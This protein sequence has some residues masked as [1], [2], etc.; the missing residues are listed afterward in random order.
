MREGAHTAPPLRPRVPSGWGDRPC[1]LPFPEGQH[2]HSELGTKG[3]SSLQRPGLCGGGTVPWNQWG[4]GQGLQRVMSLGFMEP[5][6][7]ACGPV[8]WDGP[9][10]GSDALGLSDWAKAA[11]WGSGGGPPQSHQ[12]Q[13][14]ARPGGGR[15]RVGRACCVLA[16][17][18]L[19]NPLASQPV[20]LLRGF[21]TIMFVLP[22]ASASS[23]GLTLTTI[24]LL[25][26]PC[27]PWGPSICLCLPLRSAGHWNETCHDAGSRVSV[28]R[29]AS[30]QYRGWGSRTDQMQAGGR[31]PSPR[32]QVRAQHE[33]EE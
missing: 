33:Q 22:L 27:S 1:E 16:H 17:C 15:G 9:V 10:P 31:G 29:R 4:Q 3:P 21:R 25:A 32:G 14:G 19:L 8:G 13:A 6:P 24:T 28:A 11:G 5:P 30:G 20:F 18:V 2:D 23:T 26:D 7:P 12:A